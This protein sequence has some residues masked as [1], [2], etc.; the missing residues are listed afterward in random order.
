VLQVALATY[1]RIVYDSWGLAV[2][3][4]REQQCRQAQFSRTLSI[5]TFAKASPISRW[6]CLSTAHT[7]NAEINNNI[8]TYW[9][10]EE[11]VRILL[12][13]L[14][15]PFNRWP[16][17]L[18]G[19]CAFCFSAFCFVWNSRLCRFHYLQAPKTEGIRSRRRLVSLVRRHCSPFCQL[20][21]TS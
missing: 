7:G 8:Q 19:C 2:C 3:F 6:S 11:D 4:I 5:L 15:L 16:P 20:S 9:R 17:W 1:L 10:A 14:D 21:F 12:L 18:V 13:A